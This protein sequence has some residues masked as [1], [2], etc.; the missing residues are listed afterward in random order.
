MS[1]ICVTS[2]PPLYRTAALKRYNGTEYIIT[3]FRKYSQFTSKRYKN[4]CDLLL[5]TIE[6]SEKKKILLIDRRKSPILLVSGCRGIILF[7]VI[8]IV[9]SHPALSP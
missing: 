6:M 9:A 5:Q 1:N 2:M 7:L 8:G 4:C 3:F